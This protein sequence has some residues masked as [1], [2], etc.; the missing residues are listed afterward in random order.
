M[1]WQVLMTKLKVDR[2]VEADRDRVCAL[3][4]RAH[5]ESIFSDIPFSEGKFHRAFDNTLEEPGNYLG[6]KAALGS[7]ILGYSY[8]LLGGYHIGEGARIVTV[9]SI[10]VDRRIRSGLLGGKVAVRLVRGIELWGRRHDAR[11]VLYHVTSGRGAGGTDRF[12]RRLGMTTL[13]GNYG[14]R[15]R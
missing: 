15:L 3:A 10:F 4:R 7:R 12:F 13:G 1:N 9:V 14:V 2:A 5:R 11:L 6:L 8:G